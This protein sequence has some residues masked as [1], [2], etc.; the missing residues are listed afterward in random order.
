MCYI[1]SSNINHFQYVELM[2]QFLQVVLMAIIIF[3]RIIQQKFHHT[4][5]VNIT[6]DPFESHLPL[7]H[8]SRMTSLLTWT[9]NYQLIYCPLK[10]ACYDF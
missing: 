9:Y 1:E 2:R 10:E 4:G 6:I 7:T 3:D 5:E 8:R